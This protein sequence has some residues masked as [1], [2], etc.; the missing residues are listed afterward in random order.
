MMM[1]TPTMQTSSIDSFLKTCAH[2]KREDREHTTNLLHRM[3]AAKKS[4]KIMS[5]M[6]KPSTNT[7]INTKAMMQLASQ[8]GRSSDGGI[9]SQRQLMHRWTL[10]SLAASSWM[11]S[12]STI[13]FKDTSIW[14]LAKT[15]SMSSRKA[16]QGIVL[17]KYSIAPN[18]MK[19]RAVPSKTG[20]VWSFQALASECRKPR[21]RP[22]GA[23]TPKEQIVEATQKVAKH[24]KPMSKL[25][26][27]IKIG[28]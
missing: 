5:K 4:N 23:R 12:I 2:S 7:L 9:H 18:K 17:P 26:L 22:V 8:P 27:P 19:R 6:V 28:G 15:N 1:H 13:G 16:M 10:T 24:E 14:P 25:K 11:P 20:L 21:S 3:Q